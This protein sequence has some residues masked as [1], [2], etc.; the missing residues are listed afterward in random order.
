MEKA[1]SCYQKRGTPHPSTETP[2]SPVRASYAERTADSGRTCFSTTGVINGFAING[3]VPSA[4]SVK[5]SAKAAAVLAAIYGS[6]QADA[7]LFVLDDPNPATQF[8]RSVDFRLNSGGNSANA[9]PDTPVAMTANGIATV[10]V[11]GAGAATLTLRGSSYADSVRFG[12]GYGGNGDLFYVRLVR[13][14]TMTGNLSQPISV[15]G[16]SGSG[17]ALARAQS[18]ASGSPDFI[19]LHVAPIFTQN[20]GDPLTLTLRTRYLNGSGANIF[21]TSM[22]GERVHLQRRPDSAGASQWRQSVSRRGE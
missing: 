5:L 7:S 6:G 20:V 9:S 8:S 18:T 21:G 12:V 1:G 15:T 19:T 2:C 13:N 11:P 17:A 14:Y 4:R 3:D 22:T 10:S 16:S